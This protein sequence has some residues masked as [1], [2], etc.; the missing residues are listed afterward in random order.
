MFCKR[1][2]CS[3]AD[4]AKSL[5]TK[6]AEVTESPPN[7]KKFRRDTILPPC[8]NPLM[9]ILAANVKICAQNFSHLCREILWL[10]PSR[11][12]LLTYKS[13]PFRQEKQKINAE[14]AEEAESAETFYFPN[15]LRPLLPLRPLR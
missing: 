4:W 5:L 15:N 1:D 12:V 3:R 2:G 13:L 11:F 6:P 10:W 7:L 9:G 8:L 14:E